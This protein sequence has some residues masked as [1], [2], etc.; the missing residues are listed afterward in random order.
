MLR[1][2]LEREDVGVLIGLV[3]LRIGTSGNF[4]ECGNK[5]SGFIKC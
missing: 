4:C 2:I 3:W 1:W 5:P